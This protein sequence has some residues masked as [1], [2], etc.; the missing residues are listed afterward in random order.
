MTA[1]AMPSRPIPSLAP[2]GDDV[3]A[4]WSS[5]PSHDVSRP[6]YSIRN[7]P[8]VDFRGDAPIWEEV[9]QHFPHVEKLSLTIPMSK[10]EEKRDSEFAWAQP[11]APVIAVHTL[12]ITAVNFGD[13]AMRV[14]TNWLRHSGSIFSGLRTL[15]IPARGT[16]QLG[17]TA[18]FHGCRS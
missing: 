18:E 9:L 3:V 4:A 14:A 15:L 11:D 8:F 12:R 7:V 2:R 5:S 6:A 17:W 10:P 13:E 1:L 16:H